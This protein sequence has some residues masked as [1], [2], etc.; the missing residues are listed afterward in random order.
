MARRP[1]AGVP[2][3]GGSAEVESAP[4]AT[5]P[6]LK[7]GMPLGRVLSDAAVAVLAGV[8]A[9][10]AEAIDRNEAA[11]D[12][13]LLGDAIETGD[14]RP[15]RDEASAGSLL[16]RRRLLELLRSEVVRSLTTTGATPNSA[17]L[18]DLFSR[19]ELVRAALEPRWQQ[20]F[21]AGM[22]GVNGQDLI[23]EVAHDFRSPLT[24]IMFLAETIRRGQ[25]G[26]VTEHQRHQLGIIYSAALGLASI[27]SDVI[28]MVR[29]GDSL[30]DQEPVPF[31][32]SDILE[33]VG[34][35]VRPMAEEKGLALQ[36]SPPRGDLRIGHP[37]PLSRILLNLTT[38]AIKFTD[39]G[40]VEIIATAK[41]RD[42]LQFA[43]RDTGRGVNAEALRGLYRPFRRARTEKGFHFSGTGLGLAICRKMVEAMNSEL[44]LESRVGWGTRFFFDLELPPTPRL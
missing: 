44:Q 20:Y 6:P 29:G 40:F 35:M 17:H 25:S 4:S 21:S 33:G 1:T 7:S 31:S 12:L 22:S 11:A 2:L 41:G 3:K 34:D 5:V 30:A 13:T 26:A 16:L 23:V 19:F 15:L 9:W 24:S 32:V 18:L 14:A 36:I 38:N 42:Q 27:A 43:V 28:E 10:A 37:V 39:D 8:D